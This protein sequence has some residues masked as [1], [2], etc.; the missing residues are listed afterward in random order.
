VFAQYSTCINICQEGHYDRWIYYHHNNGTLNWCTRFKIILDIA[1]GLRYLHEECRRKIAHLDIN[2]QNILLDENCN[3]K[4]ADFGL[5]KLIDRDQSKVVTV[6]RG[7][8]GYL[9]P[10]WLTSQITQK[11]EENVSITLSLSLVFT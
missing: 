9:A 6:M 1:K 4:V 11:V 3:A 7:T 8:P 10:E 2:P 5:C